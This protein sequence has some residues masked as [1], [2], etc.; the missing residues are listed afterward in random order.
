MCQDDYDSPWKEALVKYLPQFFEFFFPHIFEDVDWNKAPEFLDK[1]LPAL[2]PTNQEN[3]RGGPRV[4]DTLVELQ[5]VS[6][7]VTRILVHI[8]I[9]AQKKADFERRLFL[10]HSRILERHAKPLCSLVILADRFSNWRPSS[11]GHNVFALLTASTLHA[12]ATRQ[13]SK[14]RYTAKSR[15]IRGLHYAGLSE[16]DVRTLFKLIDWILTLSPRLKDL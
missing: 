15:L 1:E 13:G 16:K 11:F 2:A 9:Q 5:R 6:G 4:V 14:L 12:Q 7:E 8:E 10:Y 3:K